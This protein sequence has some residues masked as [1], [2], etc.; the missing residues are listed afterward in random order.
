MKARTIYSVVLS[1]LMTSAG[2]AG[3]AGVAVAEAPISG[4]GSAFIAPGA[5]FGG[6]NS[7]GFGYHSSTLQEG[8]LRG[9]AD[10][11]R[12]TGEGQ[13]WASLAAINRQEAASRYLAN[14]EQAVETYFRIKQINQAAREASRPQPLSQEQLTKIAK[15][16]APDRLNEAEY[17]RILGRLSWPAV[18][19]GDEFA[20]ERIALNDAFSARTAHDAGPASAFY[21]EVLASTDSMLEKL[22]ARLPAM[23][24]AEFI[25]ARKFLVGMA[26]EASLP[27]VA[28]GLVSAE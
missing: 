12:G 23:A 19:A 9:L 15:A 10:L 26:Y 21:G 25:A 17:D 4:S 28:K 22:A 18:L 20:S 16:Q 1:G 3:V 2:V 27:L 6:G 11:A 7:Q 14:R 8:V 24:P 5:G 13:Y